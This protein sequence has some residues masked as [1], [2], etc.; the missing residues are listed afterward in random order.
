[1]LTRTSLVISMTKTDIVL[2]PPI[3]TVCGFIVYRLIKELIYMQ[4]NRPAVTDAIVEQAYR[5]QVMSDFDEEF[6]EV[7]WEE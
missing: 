2:A 1:M 6:D 4:E 5:C 3:L 7:D